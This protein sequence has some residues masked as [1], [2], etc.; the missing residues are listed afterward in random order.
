[1]FLENVTNKA[2]DLMDYYPNPRPK[3]TIVNLLVCIIYISYCV[4]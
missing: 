3:E 1:M 4:S 2:K